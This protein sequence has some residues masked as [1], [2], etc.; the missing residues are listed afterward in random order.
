MIDEKI[1]GSEVDYRNVEFFI[2]DEFCVFVKV[3]VGEC[4]VS[5]E[6]VINSFDAP[7]P[8]SKGFFDDVRRFLRAFGWGK[9]FF[10]FFVA[11]F[12][13]PGNVHC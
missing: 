11:E 6:F 8:S 12:V 13:D 9:L 10:V 1:G 5:E 3:T 4:V 2:D 7:C